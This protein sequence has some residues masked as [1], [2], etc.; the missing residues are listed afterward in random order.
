MNDNVQVYYPKTA[1]IF[2]CLKDGQYFVQGFDNL[3]NKSVLHR[4]CDG[5]AVT[6]DGDL[7]AVHGGE[8]V[9]PMIKER[10]RT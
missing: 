4:V 6:Y 8:L 1:T 3:E 10:N 7:Y 5:L 2:S 9:T